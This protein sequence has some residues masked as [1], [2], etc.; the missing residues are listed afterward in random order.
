MRIGVFGHVGNQNLGDEALIAA[1]LQNVRR[2][3]PE[4]ELCGFTAHPQDTE[5]RHRIPA[6]PICRTN[7]RPAAAPQPERATDPPGG[8]RSAPAS[9]WAGLRAQLR[10]IPLL[11]V[12]VR[13]ARR[14]GSLRRTPLSMSHTSQGMPAT[15]SLPSAGGRV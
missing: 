8:E 3:Y 15:V 1:V 14:V 5:Q 7:G 11:P 6:F 13:A 9:A 10:R 12:L 2:R 4:A